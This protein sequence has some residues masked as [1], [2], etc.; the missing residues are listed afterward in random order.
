MSFKSIYIDYRDR[1]FALSKRLELLEP[2]S[3]GLASAIVQVQ[4]D[5]GE[6]REVI[7][8]HIREQGDGRFPSTP[9]EIVAIL[10][11]IDRESVE[12]RVQSAQRDSVVGMILRLQ[13]ATYENRKRSF[14]RAGEEVR[15]R[16]I[17][18]GNESVDDPERCRLICSDSNSTRNL[19]Q[20]WIACNEDQ[21]EAIVSEWPPELEPI[22]ELVELVD[23]LCFAPVEADAVVT[24]DATPKTSVDESQSSA[25]D[26]SKPEVRK[27]FSA[28][29]S[30]P[31]KE[32]VQSRRNQLRRSLGS[33]REKRDIVDEL[34]SISHDVPDVLTEVLDAEPTTERQVSVLPGVADNSGDSDG[35][36]HSDSLLKQEPET[37]ELIAER[38][39]GVTT[40]E[41]KVSATDLTRETVGSSQL[42]PPMQ[43][44]VPPSP[45]VAALPPVDCVIEEDSTAAATEEIE[46]RDTAESATEH[47]AIDAN[48]ISELAWQAISYERFSL[49]YCV[50]K[51]AS[52]TG[53]GMPCMPPE[54]AS[55]ALLSQLIETNSTEIAERLKTDF[56]ILHDYLQSRNDESAWS[57][58]LLIT[59]SAMRPTLIA[60]MADAVSLL[61]DNFL[62]SDRL[63]SYTSLCR[64]IAQYGV[65]RLEVDPAMLTGARELAEWQEEFASQLDA[66]DAWWQSEKCAKVIYAHTTNVWHHWLRDDEAIGKTILAIQSAGITA[67]PLIDAF[68]EDWT[69]ERDIDRRCKLT[70]DD[71][72]GKGAKRRPIDGRALQAVRQ[73]V[74][75]LCDLLGALKMKIQAMPDAV[76][77]FV[78]T[79]VIE[80]R[81]S[82][83]GCIDQAVAELKEYRSGGKHASDVQAALD[84]SVVNLGEVKRMFME[85][86]LNRPQSEQVSQI[87]TSELALVPGISVTLHS[88]NGT[89][90]FDRND[91]RRLLNAVE[92]PLTEEDA[93]TIQTNQSNHA[94]AKRLLFKIESRPGQ[95]EVAERLRTVHEESLEADRIRLKKEAL[96]AEQRIDDA[97]CYDLV[98]E[99]FRQNLAAKVAD[100]TGVVDTE[101]NLAPAFASISK[102][103]D[104]LYRLRG[105]RLREV[106][107]RFEE[108]KRQSG[109]FD[110]ND[111]HR[112][113]STLNARDFATADE[114]IN[115]VR[116]GQHLGSLGVE[117]SSTFDNFFDSFLPDIDEYLRNTPTEH[118]PDWKRQLEEGRDVV[119]NKPFKS[120]EHRRTAAQ[121]LEAW[122][123]TLKLRG[124]EE[125][126]TVHLASLFKL[127]G[128]D[129]A[130]VKH[131]SHGTG[132]SLDSLS[133]QPI[134]N[135]NICAVPQYGSNA[136]GRYQ[137]LSI[138]GKTKDPDID[139]I[140]SDTSLER[141]GSDV[142]LIV[143]FCG[144]LPKSRRRVITKQCWGV[145]QF[146]LLDEFLLMF[147]ATLE[148]GVQHAFFQCTLPFT[149]AQPYS[150]T[151]SFVP[152]EM[153]FGRGEEYK[154]IIS[155][156][157]T[158]LVFGGRQLGKSVLL[159]E[160][161][162]R[163]HNP[164]DGCIVR[165]IDLKNRGIGTQRPAV[166][167]W[168]EIGH[169][170]HKDGVLKHSASQEGT[171]RAR[172][173][174]WLDQDSRRRILLL[175][176]E[177]D[178]FLNQDSQ[179][180][181]DSSGNAFPIISQIKGL[182]DDT[183]RRFKVVFAGL[184]NVQRAARDK[185]TPMGHLGKS[186]NIGP[187]IDNGEWQQ[188]KA[189]IETPMR[190]MGFVFESPDLVTRILSHTNFY[191]SLIQIF[192]RH[193]LRSMHKRN[194][195]VIDFRKSPPYSIT[196][197]DIERVY[198]S[199]ELQAEIRDRFELTLNLDARYRLIAFLIAL[200][201]IEMREDGEPLRGLTRREIHER[202]LGFWSEG[203]AQDTS[204][205]GFGILL[206]EM[207]GLGVLRRDPDSK[208][209]L[210]SAN[211][212]NL[213]GSK[214]RIEESLLD[215]A[216]SPPPSE[217]RASTFRRSLSDDAIR[218][219]PLTSQQE[220]RVLTRSNGV[221][222]LTGCPLAMLDDVEEA[223]E[224]L[225]KPDVHVTTYTGA[226]DEDGFLDWLDVWRR[227]NSGL[228]IV[229][230]PAVANWSQGWIQSTH[231]FLGKKKSATKNFVRVIFVADP[232]KLWNVE[233]DELLLSKID[234]IQLHPWSQSILDRWLVDNSFN[235]EMDGV[236]QLHEASG[237]W[238]SLIQ[239]LAIECGDEK[240]L[241]MNRLLTLADSWPEI[242]MQNDWLR[243]PAEPK[244]FFTNW[245]GLDPLAE[246]EVSDLQ[247]IAGETPVKR[248]IDWA[249]QLCYIRPGKDGTW[250]LNTLVARAL[251]TEAKT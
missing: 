26:S 221:T 82:V 85:A 21:R 189:L 214:D 154:A 47:A 177:A 22:A 111:F 69:D 61:A 108:L 186:I 12:R 242:T 243:L 237:G 199:E 142:P 136:Q 145:H 201:T 7:A 42:T 207:I 3:E 247:D 169:C 251:Q 126:R 121:V 215:V 219:S 153:F 226:G 144:R 174:E 211:V 193:L 102:V 182:M 72:R 94:A 168:D 55:V 76:D 155:R 116:K 93:F 200:Q 83:L 228:S 180:I 216:N 170:L 122:R 59:S 56:S 113:E 79:K 44:S 151:A 2:V 68:V 114:Y 96:K 227:G 119:F 163:L 25:Q 110:A 129:D 57:L 24:S 183:E 31:S 88:P 58:R 140:L 48:Q 117:E 40:V 187:L 223:F 10:D 206:D 249:A 141:Q 28:S 146:L 149:S 245:I 192:C 15:L 127:L 34:A 203:F 220:G 66:L 181:N 19:L 172:V 43:Q 229:I 235:R 143:L 250:G 139:K 195:S 104:E 132:W 11:L 236:I 35:E 156:D 159:R 8:N 232:P 194:Q 45:S 161:E 105:D 51:A 30:I 173:K 86:R 171:I 9:E 158:H 191:P 46:E 17:S 225:N 202:A 18:C 106:R 101:L 95:Q 148:Q 125:K 231:T 14:A 87:L 23:G 98:N 230:V 16:A 120:D 212:L 124:A 147:L 135:R 115:L 6:I 210:R 71:K 138:D 65:L 130:E 190:Q 162:R 60:P 89:L 63:K 20:A 209:A 241:W 222:L 137:L 36:A 75:Y 90:Q 112:I 152:I 91:L 164:G 123:R 204:F 80:C 134:A 238:G 157:P 37:Q 188:A 64:A 128:F 103:N 52:Q 218:R 41:T 29:T 131:S 240:H 175:M 39:D 234:P 196:M 213:M 73:K 205:D 109:D 13:G 160:A 233:I 198:Q 62:P 118:L 70:D 178:E 217:Y 81:T 1:V 208:Y 107:N 92:E 248:L 97:V 33:L 246:F 32:N 165:W 166:E 179:Q 197:K 99:T 54:V 100:L 77:D 224:S 49:A 84:T 150:I 38:T 184:H 53:A 244:E 27:S 185:N 78:Q 5:A 133:V 176:D 4:E 239:Q 50:L 67:I 167:L 74:H